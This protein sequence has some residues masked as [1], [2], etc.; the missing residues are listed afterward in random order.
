M[1]VVLSQPVAGK[2]LVFDGRLM[3]LVAPQLQ[4]RHVRGAGAHCV[5]LG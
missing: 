4:A 1:Q 3:H 5:H 2:H